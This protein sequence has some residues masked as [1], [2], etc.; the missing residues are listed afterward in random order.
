MLKCYLSVPEVDLKTITACYFSS[1]MGIFGDSNELQFGAC[2][3][4]KT[5]SKSREQR[6]TFFDREK[7]VG[8]GCDKQRPLE[9]TGSL[10]CN[11][12]SLAGMSPGKEKFFLHSAW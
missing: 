4:W 10:K 9:E 3:L 1:K 2:S 7:G 5:A 11:G 8:R 12:F 6:R